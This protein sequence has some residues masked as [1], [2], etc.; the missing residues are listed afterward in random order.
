MKQFCTRWSNEFNPHHMFNQINKLQLLIF[1]LFKNPG[2]TI[3]FQT[4]F[5]SS[6]RKCNFNTRTIKFII[7]PS[8]YLEVGFHTHVVCQRCGLL[9]SSTLEKPN[10]RHTSR[11]TR[12]L[13][14]C[15]IS[16]VIESS[17][18]GHFQLFPCQENF[19][20]CKIK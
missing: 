10:W 11:P 15:H 2:W 19:P 14:Y 7:Q 13:L 6:I 3:F 12:T 16:H 5:N 9:L 8:I 17:I 18:H 20:F 4:P 1:I